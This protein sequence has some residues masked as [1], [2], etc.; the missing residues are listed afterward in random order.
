MERSDIEEELVRL[1]ALRIKSFV[2][3]CW[4]RAARWGK[5]LDFLLRGAEPRG[6]HV[7]VEDDGGR[8]GDRVAHDGAGPRSEGGRSS[9][10]ASRCRT[11]SNLRGIP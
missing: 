8:S 3:R 2:K 6:Q 11:W 5:R 10:H 9:G 4:T 7:A 1:H